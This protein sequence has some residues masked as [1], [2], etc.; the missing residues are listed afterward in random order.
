M[1]FTDFAAIQPVVVRVF[2]F[3]QAQEAY[4]YLE[5]GRHFGKVVIRVAQ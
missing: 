5:S 1:R 4:T 2:R 3:E